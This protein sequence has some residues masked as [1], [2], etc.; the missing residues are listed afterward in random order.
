MVVAAAQRCTVVA[1][2]GG[3]RRSA[4]HNAYGR[5]TGGTA[6]ARPAG[7]PALHLPPCCG[8]SRDRAPSLP[9]ADLQVSGRSCS[10]RS[11]APSGRRRSAAWQ[12]RRGGGQVRLA[13]ITGTEAATEAAITGAEQLDQGSS[14][15]SKVRLPS[16]QVITCP[17]PLADATLPPPPPLP[18]SACAAPTAAAAAA[19][20]AQ[21]YIREWTDPEFAAETMASFPD[22]AI[23]TVEE[24]RVRGT[25]P[26]AL[27]VRL[28]NSCHKACCGALSTG[29]ALLGLGCTGGW[30]APAPLRWV[31]SSISRRLLPDVAG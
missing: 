18:P 7:S 31:S 11:A 30:A 5:A 13:A 24:A 28:P 2:A 14:A 26:L 23:A 16:A 3:W 6:G 10:P 27:L 29:L 22:K 17:G 12:R 1:A 4:A 25:R 20:A 19:L 15:F 21:A 8:A 9:P